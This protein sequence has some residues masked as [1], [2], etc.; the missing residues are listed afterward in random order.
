MC[1]INGFCD[2]NKKLDKE[3]IEKANAT[4]RHRGPD[5]G[6]TIVF[7]TQYANIGLGHRRLSILD[8]SPLGH[9]PM[10]SD[11]KQV[12][13]T[14]NG[15]IYN[16][17]EVRTQLE[18]E[19]HQFISKSDTEV[20]IKAYL[21][22]GIECI[23][24]FIGMF[25]FVIYDMRIQQIFLCRDRAGVKPL[26]YYFADGCLLFSSEL[27]A[28]HQYPNFKKDIEPKAVSLF[29]SYGYI[30]EPYSI[31]KNTYKLSPGNY[32]VL[33]IPSQRLKL[34]QYWNV[35]D[36]YNKPVIKI[37]EEEAADHLEELLISAFEYRMVSDVPVG[38]FLS[39]GYDSSLVTAILQKNSMHKIKT[40]TIGFKEDKFNEAGYAKE[41]ANHLGTDHHEYYCSVKEAQEI[42]PTLS[43]F[44]DEPF[45]DSSALPTMLVSKFARKHV[46][47][48]LSADAGDEIFA[49]YGRYDQLVKIKKIKNYVPSFLG[50]A[51]SKLL[52][53]IP[54]LDSPRYHKLGE[55]LSA[56]GELD[57]SDSLSRHFTRRHLNELLN[58]ARD[59][60]AR[61]IDLENT[62]FKSD[63]INTVLA[64]D[65]K[66]YLADDILTKIDRAT[67]SV[68]LE[69]REPF[70]DHRIVEWAAQLPSSLKYNTG[71][72]KYL[73]KKLTHR[74]LPASMMDRPKMGFG[75][76]VNKWLRGDLR[77]L[78]LDI[79]S[80]KNLRK[81]NLLNED[82]V[83]KLRDKYLASSTSDTAQLWL[84]LM[85]QMW[86]NEWMD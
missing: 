60:R 65:Y 7:H 15:E 16:F 78:V 84:I 28:F 47:V 20:V 43:Y 83:I 56:T 33:D 62:P 67:M 76:P 4:L 80:S 73:L 23:Q 86:W 72:K 19:G 70:L 61:L 14:L 41:V 9:Q 32:A 55:I 81:H 57:I 58:I 54:F 48:A 6:E 25:A 82:A 63:F 31:F 12:V 37:D 64:A 30:K 2:F 1:G 34:H 85:F 49:G 74:Y 38:V 10:Y 66:T 18:K 36:Y 69:G 40:F 71:K 77:P 79:I 35:L 13:I 3:E 8:L 53:Q 26:Y 75:I 50:N 42:I 45:G 68:G 21:A 5:D 44:Y 11:D 51:S 39:G 59:Y 22:Y 29:F 27:K 46:T 24:K 17:K 52:E